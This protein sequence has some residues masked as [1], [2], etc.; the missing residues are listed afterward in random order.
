M[1]EREEKIQKLKDYFEKRDDVVMAFLFGSQAQDRAHSASDWDIAVY[2]RPKGKEI[3]WEIEQEYQ[4]ERSIWSECSD[5]LDTDAVDLVVLNRAPA[6][7]AD[8]ALNGMPLVVKDHALWLRFLLAITRNA[9]DFRETAREYAAIYWRSKSL[10]KEDAYE[11]ERRLVF[12]DAELRALSDCSSLTWQDYQH[13][14]TKRLVAER[15]IENIMN[16]VIDISKTVLASAKHAPMPQTYKEIMRIAGLISPF[17]QDAAEQLSQWAE[18]RNILAHEYLDYRW[19]DIQR[20][21]Q[22]GG[23]HVQTFLDAARLFLEENRSA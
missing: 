23:A 1:E 16:A 9:I 11:F 21:L 3:E 14:R 12:L 7:V 2:F 17:S 15:T 4:Q 20:F 8:T 22:E 5:M 19:K 10:T 18:L 6:V 13:E